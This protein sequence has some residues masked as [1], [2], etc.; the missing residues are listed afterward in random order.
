[1]R[2]RSK[3][4]P[5]LDSRAIVLETERLIIRAWQDKDLQDLFDYASMEGVGQMAGWNPHVTIKDSKAILFNFMTNRNAMALELK[6]NNKV[7][8]SISVEKIYTNYLGEDFMDLKGRE[9][10]YVLNKDYW[11]QGL[12]PEAVNKVVDYLLSEVDYDY[13]MC[14][15]FKDNIQSQKVIEKTG[16][17]LI[18]EIEYSTLHK[19]N[20]ATLLYV[21]SRD[22]I[23]L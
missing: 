20:V 10:G 23:E 8:G 21:K 12:M 11:G 1:M 3:L 14:A 17:K 7:V 19:A 9:V 2:K 18:T 16:F 6:S 5:E 4:R 13:L 22:D 15:H